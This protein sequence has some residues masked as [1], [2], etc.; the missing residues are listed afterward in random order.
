[1]LA[2]G[3]LAILFDALAAWPAAAGP[4]DATALAVAA[5]VAALWAAFWLAVAGHDRHLA[6][7]ALIAVTTAGV[8]L[9]QSLSGYDVRQHGSMLALPVLMA[10]AAFRW[11]PALV[12]VA[13]LGLAEAGWD[14]AAGL[15]GLA[16]LGDVIKV[17]L[18]G[19]LAVAARS[20]LD[21]MRE[22]DRARD[23]LATLAVAEE[24]LRLAGD[25]DEVLRARI[26]EL[27]AELDRLAG[28]ASPDSVETQRA[29]VRAVAAAARGA[30]REVRGAVD[31]YRRDAGAP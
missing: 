25:V 18:W 30:I 31:G 28:E 5:V 26:E 9:W 1:V 16:A 13:V 10:G 12:V 27:A 24:R 22:L 20:A 19:L 6:A 15:A 29:G 11:R 8:A 21:V 23:E 4:R 3:S 17:V 14:A 7:I 2:V